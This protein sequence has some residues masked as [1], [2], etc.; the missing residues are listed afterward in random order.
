MIQTLQHRLTF[1]FTA[2]T[3]LILTLILGITWFYQWNQTH[4]QRNTQ[5]Q[6]Q[7]LNL[8]GKLDLE[9]DIS[10]NWLARSE[11]DNRLIIHIEENQRPLFF[12][13]S[14]IP[15]TDRDTLIGLAKK[16]ASEEGV[17]TLVRPFSY[18]IKQSSIFPLKGE[19]HDTYI[20]T[21]TVLA[22]EHG[23]RS[24]VL[25]ADTTRQNRSVLL[26]GILF[27]LLDLLGIFALFLSCRF[28]VIQALKPVEKY[29]KKQTE[30][31]AAASHELRSPL[32]VIQ[33]C[34]TTILT[35]PEQTSRMAEMIQKECIRSGNLVKNLLLLASADSD[36]GS[37]ELTQFEV[38]TLL[39]QLFESYELLCKAKSIRLTLK[40]PEEFLP[41]VFGNPQ[42]CRQI[43]TI[44]LDNAIAYGCPFNPDA[45][46]M[47]VLLIQAEHTGKEI[48][49]SITDHG[50]GIPDEQKAQVF[51]RFYRADTSRN[52]KEHFGLGLS[53]A[54]TLAQQMNARIELTDANG[55]GT[56]FRLCFPVS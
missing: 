43:L 55:S 26:Q 20:G 14:W 9:S 23:F 38:D 41:K 40:L 48:V 34:A 50:P 28:I 3:G 45:P 32:S 24:L 37:A 30:F 54:Q 16:T 11:Y 2:A 52:K 51:D 12:S 7:L 27:L 8:T 15:D 29:Q 31:V 35:L 1:L 56:I 36:N 18:T 25:L 33:N 10:D 39:L 49:L 44:F 46:S 19:Y 21:V 5:F 42:W 47:P 17:S 22:T 53:I 4:M 13:G 6:N